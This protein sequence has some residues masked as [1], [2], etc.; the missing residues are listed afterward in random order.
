MNSAPSVDALARSGRIAPGE[1][2]ADQAYTRLR[3]AILA[4]ELTAGTRL[5]VP[6]VA[7]RLGISRSPAREAIARIAS[8]GLATY[9]PRRGA[10]VARIETTDLV[11]IYEL[12]EVLEGMACRLAAV[13]IHDTTI[14]E[15][16]AV[17][18]DHASAVAADDVERH[19]TLDASFHQ[20]IRVAAQNDRLR[21]S[22]DRLQGQIR[23]AMD[24]TRR[25]PGGMG[26]ALAEHREILAA[27][28]ARDP[29]AAERAA[30]A[31]VARLRGSL[32]S[33]EPAVADPHGEEAGS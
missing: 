27:V 8:E 21:E 20:S 28:A 29:D 25:S 18:A 9:E 13:R 16:H 33:R 3:D 5:S 7:R 15:L 32:P 17:V 2:L 23:I 6:D 11:E 30:R 24:T 26:Q 10:I 4:H 1:A 12:R 19:M 14:E 31:H 22:L